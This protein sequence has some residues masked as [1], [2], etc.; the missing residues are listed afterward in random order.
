L[1]FE[2]VGVEGPG[3]EIALGLVDVLT[4]QMVHLA[5]RFDAFGEGLEPEV[6]A[7]LDEGPDECLGFR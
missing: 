2:H 6:L 4:T 7:E 5:C 1:G 3:E